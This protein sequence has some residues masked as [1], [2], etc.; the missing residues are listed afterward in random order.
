[1]R[2]IYLHRNVKIKFDD[3]SKPYPR[4]RMFYRVKIFWI[5]HRW[6]EASSV[7]QEHFYYK[8]GIPVKN[9]AV[10][11]IEGLKKARLS[12]KGVRR[13]RSKVSREVNRLSYR[14]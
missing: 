1:M 8:N 6:M 5:F 2:D 13:M 14:G 9:R 12:S 3:P 10:S 7:F 4:A 11:I